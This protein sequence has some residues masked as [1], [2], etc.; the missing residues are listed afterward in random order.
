M[1]LIIIEGTDNT[2]KDTVI[3][4]IMK[5]Y[6]CVKVYHCCKPKGSTLEECQ[7][8]QFDAFTAIALHNVI[9]YGNGS[10]D[11]RRRACGNFDGV[12]PRAKKSGLRTR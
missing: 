1:K 3:S 10:A 2:G 12:L 6:P 11:N 8:E 7:Q 9:D 5:K 4:N